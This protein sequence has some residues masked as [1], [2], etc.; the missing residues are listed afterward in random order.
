MATTS[1]VKPS[2]ELLVHAVEHLKASDVDQRVMECGQI[3]ILYFLKHVVNTAR[4]RYSV[5]RILTIKDK[6]SRDRVVRKKKKKK[7][8]TISK[9]NQQFQYWLVAMQYLK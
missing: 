7:K 9:K 4:R 6:V 1:Q 3:C 5:M 8:L 2:L